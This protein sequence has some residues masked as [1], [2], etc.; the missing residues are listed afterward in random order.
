V[1]KFSHFLLELCQFILLILEE[2][3]RSSYTLDLILL[4]LSGK[5]VQL[6]LVYLNELIDVVQLFFAQL[7]LLIEIGWVSFVCLWQLR[8]IENLI[9]GLTQLV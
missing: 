5:R 8:L 7:K 1:F 4:F 3:F 2:L 9:D 6:P